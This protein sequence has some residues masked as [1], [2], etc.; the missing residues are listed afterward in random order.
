MWWTDGLPSDDGQVGAA[1]VC[2]HG[3]ERRSRRSCLG[4]GR[5]EVFDSEGWAIG[6]ALDVAIGK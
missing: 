6:L 3:T 4:T 5:M 1:V 2:K